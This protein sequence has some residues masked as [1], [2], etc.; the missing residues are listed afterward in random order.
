[1]RSRI[2]GPSIAP[3]SP[4]PS[5]TASTVCHAVVDCSNPA[6]APARRAPSF[7]EPR[8]AHRGVESRQPRVGVLPG[9]RTAR[10]GRADPG[11]RAGKGEIMAKA[12]TTATRTAK[13]T[14]P[15]TGAAPEKRAPAAPVAPAARGGDPAARSSATEVP[16]GTL[17]VRSYI[18]DGAVL[19]AFDMNVADTADL[20]GFAIHCPAQ[21]PDPGCRTASTSRAV[22]PPRPRRTRGPGRR[23]TRRRSRSSGGPTS[24]AASPAT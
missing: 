1:M 20:A 3:P 12:R 24:R 9:D 17:R 8:G 16:K 10:R 5:T 11:R 23:R 19:L 4:W 15:G 14:K 13:A 6:C 22:T 2:I 18:G 21:V 7:R